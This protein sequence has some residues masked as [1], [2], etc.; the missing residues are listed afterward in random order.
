M[1]RIVFDLDRPTVGL[2]NVGVEEIKGVEA[3]REAGQILRAANLAELDYRGFVEGDDIG[4]GTTDVVVTEGFAGNIALKTAE[5]TARQISEYLRAAMSRTIRG[6]I[7]Y[8][9][10]K[11]A[12]LVL[13]EKVDPRKVNGGVF[14]GLNGVVV[15]SH[16]GADAESFAAAIDTGFDVV[17][18]GMNAQIANM[19]AEKSA[20]AAA[21]LVLKATAS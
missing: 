14:L 19:L 5:G 16:G 1:A 7:G 20:A 3:V 18:N 2:L 17:R 13:R 8:L 12:F 6:R 9:F 21:S 10:A 15:K 4:K 11:Q